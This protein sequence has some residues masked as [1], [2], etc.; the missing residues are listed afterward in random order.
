MP[1]T[2]T[3]SFSLG[4]GADSRGHLA[5][6]QAGRGGQGKARARRCWWPRREEGHAGPQIDIP[7]VLDSVGANT[8]S[9]DF[10]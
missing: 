10:C 4:K 8:E 9:M 2:A 7:A 1:V 6:Q 3:G 5:S